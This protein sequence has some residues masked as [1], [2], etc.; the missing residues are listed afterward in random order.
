MRWIT[1]TSY[2]FVKQYYKSKVETFIYFI[3]QISN[4]SYLPPNV[5]LSQILLLG[6]IKTTDVL[7]S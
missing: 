4:K 6:Y 1:I 3:K 7:C 2:N 5:D